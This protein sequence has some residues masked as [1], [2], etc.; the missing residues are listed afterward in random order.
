M[1]WKANANFLWYSGNDILKDVDKV[2]GT[3]PEHWKPYFYEVGV[4]EPVKDTEPVV[5]DE[6]IPV[7]KRMGRPFGSKNI[8]RRR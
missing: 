3:I 8:G 7:S 2:N 1:V 4:V 5:T 6:V